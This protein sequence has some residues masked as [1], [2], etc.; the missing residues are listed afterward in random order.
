L[1][2]IEALEDIARAKLI[3]ENNQER[4]SALEKKIS[5]TLGALPR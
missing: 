1:L 5:N 4:F 3:P 2:K